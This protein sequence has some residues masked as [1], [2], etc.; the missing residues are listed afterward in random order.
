MK[1]I[2]ASA[3]PRR[4]E[5][6]SLVGI[7]VAVK[8][9]EIDETIL[10]DE[11]PFEAIVRLANAKNQAVF[12][13]FPDACVISADTMVVLDNVAFNKPRDKDEAF[14]MLKCLSGRTHQVIT[15]CVIQTAMFKEEIFSTTHVT[16]T[17]LSD[18]DI[19]SYVE[20]LEPMDKA[21][22]YAI[23]GRAGW[24]IERIEGDFYTVVGLP[25]NQL[26]KKLREKGIIDLQIL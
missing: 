1:I 24:M 13:Q 4:I 26:V 19:V 18:H 8:P 23:Q 10:D 25:L 6:L 7:Q 5:L 3:S 14:N 9:A 11:N 17:S 2:L 22:A 21:G 12:S 15:A 20:T 16:M